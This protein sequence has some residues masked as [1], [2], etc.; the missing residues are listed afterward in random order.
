M[1]PGRPVRRGDPVVRGSAWIAQTRRAFDWSGRP[2]SAAPFFDALIILTCTWG[3][4]VSWRL[5]RDLKRLHPGRLIYPGIYR[6]VRGVARR[7]GDELTPRRSGVLRSAARSFAPW[8]SRWAF[9]C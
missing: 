1:S 5:W 8:V 7:E 2:L 4:A 6:R 9:T 3:L